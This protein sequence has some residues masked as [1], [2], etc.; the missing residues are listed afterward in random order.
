MKK[1]STDSDLRQ[2]VVEQSKKMAKK[3]LR[4]GEQ[5]EEQKSNKSSSNLDARSS[6]DDGV[7][8][9]GGSSIM[10][11]EID[12]LRE[13]KGES[14]LEGIGKGE[15]AAEAMIEFGK[16]GVLREDEVGNCLLLTP[17]TFRL[18]KLSIGMHC[19]V[20]TSCFLS[21]AKGTHTITPVIS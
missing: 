7:S 5:E 16:E 11:D 20:E 9:R 15:E 13:D 2:V 6:R 10:V 19:A 12:I 1:Q 3:Q 4:M 21:S 8:R 17:V 18:S 14:T